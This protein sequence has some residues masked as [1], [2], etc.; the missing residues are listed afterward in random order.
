MGNM[1]KARIVQLSDFPIPFHRKLF[2][3]VDRGTE[4][5]LDTGYS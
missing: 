5:Y 3:Y 2:Y 4:D 1:P